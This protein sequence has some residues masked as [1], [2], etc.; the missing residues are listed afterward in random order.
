MSL[1]SILALAS[2]TG[3]D[4]QLS[5]TNAGAEGAPV[6]G[7]A[8]AAG[9]APEETASVSLALI[10]VPADAACLELV[11]T[12]TDK[13]WGTKSQL[14]TITPGAASATLTMGA[15]PSGSA[16][17]AARTFN[18]ACAQV[19]AST[20]QTWVTASS[21][22]L[23]LVAAQTATVSIVLRK[24]SAVQVTAS[25]D[26]AA[27]TITPNP[28]DL[29]G[30]G[31]G[32]MNYTFYTVNNSGSATASIPASL[33]GTD[34]ADFSLTANGCGATLA[35]GA[36]CTGIVNLAPKS[37]GPKTVTLNVGTASATVTG[38]GL[39]GEVHVTPSSLAFGNVAVGASATLTITLTNTSSVSAGLGSSR[40]GDYDHFAVANG[41][42]CG[43]S[44]APSAT[45][46]KLLSFAPLSEGLKSG[47]FNIAGSTVP[48]SG[49]GT[50]ALSIT[51]NPIDLGG[52]GMGFMNY[53]FYTVRNS[54][55]ATA[56]IPASLSGTDLAD[57]SLTANGCGATLA[58]GASC[59]GIVNLAP[60]SPGLKTV[61]LTVGSASATVT[62]FGLSGEVRVTPSSLAFGNVAVG[63]SAT[64]TITLNNTGS[65]SAGLGS[66]RG[67]DYDHFAVANGGTCGTSLA[68]SATCTKLLSF[69]PLSA[70]LKSGTFNIAGTTVPLS[71]TGTLTAI[72]RINAGSG[73]AVSPFTGD[74]YYSGGTQA[75]YSATINVSGVTNAAPAAVYQSERYGNMTYTFPSL[76]A[77]TAHTVRLHMAELYQS[78]AGKRL[79]NVSINGTAVLTNFDTYVA[80]G[81]AK[82]KAVVREFNTTSNASGQIVVQFTNV[83]DNASISGIEILK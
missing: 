64:L 67:G 22:P 4:A 74:Q 18:V 75:S 35:A 56:S 71:G 41:G 33:S 28:I 31:L 36:S 48:L 62:G 80:A 77:S 46:T 55:S 14:F 27:L 12:P 24:P 58:A 65:V 5:V 52:L 11:V 69:A 82:N 3:S 61:T 37:P 30:I 39:S 25:F 57:F 23:T 29:G 79:F 81:N 53:T 43:T 16:T 19:T 68:P 20:S 21:V 8:V 13:T 78:A 70:G 54:G 73:T 32:F 6:G 9:E 66:S 63:A 60:K 47:T 51:P 7:P 45:C 40:G 83:T 17:I 72:Y 26:D 76:T 38:F 1:V 49:T 2:C 50:G 10:N 44:L 59:T 34:L 15:L 42:T